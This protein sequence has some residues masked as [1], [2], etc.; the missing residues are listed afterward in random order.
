MGSV[1]WVVRST[2]TVTA[3]VVPAVRVTVT[4]VPS[5]EPAAT[6]SAV[7]LPAS[8]PSTTVTGMSTANG[9]PASTFARTWSVPTFSTVTVSSSG[10]VGLPLRSRV[11]S[12][13]RPENTSSGSAFSWL[14]SNFRCPDL[15]G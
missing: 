12:D 14:F 13:V 7:A 5:T 11:T 3:A 6:P 9:A 15:V 8:V 4:A 10:L 1:G 2:S